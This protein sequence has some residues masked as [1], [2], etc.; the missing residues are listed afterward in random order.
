MWRGVN[1]LSLVTVPSRAHS[2][3][4]YHIAVWTHGMQPL[5]ALCNLSLVP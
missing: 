4:V 2:P 5:N 3:F 1:A